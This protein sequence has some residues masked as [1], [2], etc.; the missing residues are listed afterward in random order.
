M[1]DDTRSGGRD[2]YRAQT[3]RDFA[4]IGD[5]VIT[6]DHRYGTVFDTFGPACTVEFA[7]GDRDTFSRDEVKRAEHTHPGVL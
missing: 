1:T 3:I 4:A 7:N 2:A 6:P 5:K